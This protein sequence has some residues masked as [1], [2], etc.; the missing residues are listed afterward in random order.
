MPLCLTIMELALALSDH[1]KSLVLKSSW[2]TH[3]KVIPIYLYIRIFVTWKKLK[4]LF[5]HLLNYFRV[6][7]PLPLTVILHGSYCFSYYRS[8]FPLSYDMISGFYIQLLNTPKT[9]TSGSTDL[10]TNVAANDF[11]LY[12]IMMGVIYWYST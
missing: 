10:L 1:L 9:D 4:T 6:I 8:K 11:V 2:I 5:L 12:Y 7:V 3:S